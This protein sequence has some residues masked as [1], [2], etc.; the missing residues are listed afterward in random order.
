ESCSKRCPRADTIA[1]MRLWAVLALCSCYEAPAA[2]YCAT[3]CTDSC[4]DGYACSAGVCVATDGHCAAPV[5]N[6]VA[7]GVGARHSCALGDDGTISCWGDNDFG[8]IGAGSAV[9]PA[10]TK[11]AGT[12]E[13]LAVGADHTCAL[14][15]DGVAT[16]WGRNSE[17]ES[18]GASS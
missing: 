2:D 11:V 7:I 13:A 10:A 9:V 8:Q 1:W 4:P 14:T 3:T 16:C 17:G 18:L 5:I 15:L 6:A 12:Y